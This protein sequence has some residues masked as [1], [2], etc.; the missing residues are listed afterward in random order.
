[1]LSPA[2][3]IQSQQIIV[4]AANYFLARQYTDGLLAAAVFN[5]LQ[6]YLE[7]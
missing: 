5:C 6:I 7:E 1:L 2:F 4:K 3:I